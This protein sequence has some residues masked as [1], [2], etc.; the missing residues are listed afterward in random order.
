M[1]HFIFLGIWML[2]ASCGDSGDVT[3]NT[4]DGGSPGEA[5]GSGKKPVTIVSNPV[6]IMKTEKSFSSGTQVQFGN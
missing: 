6:E 3:V 1:K 4:T 2:M 5:S